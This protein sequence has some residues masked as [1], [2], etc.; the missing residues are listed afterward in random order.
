MKILDRYVVAVVGLHFLLALAALLAVF[1]VINMTQELKEVGSGGYGVRDALWFVVMTLP[2]EAFQLFPAAALIGTVNGLGALVSHNEVIALSAAGVSRSRLTGAALQ[3][4]ALL[5]VGAVVIGEVVAPPA[6]QRARAERSAAVS[7]GLLLSTPTGLWARD[8]STFVNIKT[9]LASGALRD[10]YFYDVDAGQRLRW[11]GH[12]H[13]ATH[14]AG[15]WTLDDV[16]ERHLTPGGVT[17]T[18]Y[19]RRAWVTHLDPQQLRVLLFPPEAL[20]IAELRQSIEALRVRGENPGPQELAFWRR[21]TM[22]LVSAVMVLLAIPFV[23]TTLRGVALGRRLAVGA[24]AGIGFQMFAHTFGRFGL[25][26]GLD[27]FVSAA[28]PGFLALA[29]LGLSATRSGW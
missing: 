13:A 9:P 16:V 6:S 18:R 3:A 23:A 11:F 17:T 29:L 28:F 14:A 5:A 20:S 15:Q 4:A 25:V 8:G 26:Y 2:A 27:P 10:L 12:A 7:G 22:P 19:A 24:L 1:S 21:V